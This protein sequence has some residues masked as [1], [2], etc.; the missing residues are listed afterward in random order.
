M[1]HT[2]RRT[3]LQSAAGALF[4]GTARAEPLAPWTPGTLDI[5]HISTGRGSCAFLLCPDGTT[6]MVDCGAHE[7][8][9]DLA[10]FMIDPKPDGSRR[11]GEWIARYIGRQMKAARR[12]ELDIF[13]LTHFHDDH[14]GQFTDGAPKSRLGNY[15]LS[16]ISDLAESLP[17]GRIFDRGWPDYDYPAPPDDPNQRNY[18]AFVK[19]PG[20]KTARFEPG[21]LDQLELRT[22]T[23]FPK[24][25]IRNLVANGEVWTGAGEATQRHF[26]DLA[27]LKSEL[28]PTEN[29][30]SLGIRLSYGKFDYFTAG[31]MSFDTQYGHNRWRD[32]ETP[33]ARVAGPVDVAVANHHGYLDATGP[34]FVAALQPRAFVIN[35]WDSAHPTM[36]ALANM[37]SRDL[38]PGDR[39]IYATAMKPEAKIA[40][41]ALTGLRS[42]NGHVIFR[43]HPPGDRFEVFITTN[44]DESGRVIARFGP[45]VCS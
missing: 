41:R 38:Y 28:Y 16:G 33:V 15:R 12:E 18:Q 45:Y 1:S 32:I 14:M 43:V 4:V 34:N 42:D 5:H 44:E 24:F 8:T 10:R 36:G 6:M 40:I 9:A 35:A 27:T 26:P 17:V 7:P 20:R 11:P 23:A 30:C 22:P 2:H 21:R 31:D 3:F 37:L 25:H 13:L 39:D 29:M 19:S